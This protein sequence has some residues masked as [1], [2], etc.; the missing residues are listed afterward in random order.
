MEATTPDLRIREQRLKRWALRRGLDLA[1]AYGGR[2]WFLYDWLNRADTARVFY[3]LD[4]VEEALNASSP[5][6]DAGGHYPQ[7]E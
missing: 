1:K 3:D 2:A 6:H 5:R 7:G 4:G